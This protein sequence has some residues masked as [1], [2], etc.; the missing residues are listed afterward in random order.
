MSV[1]QRT[2]RRIRHDLSRALAHSADAHDAALA[3]SA[4]FCDSVSPR[5]S[6]GTTSTINASSTGDRRRQRA[7]GTDQA[8]RASSERT[9]IGQCARSRLNF[10]Y[11]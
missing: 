11:A 8:K 4:C 7:G 3:R 5:L 6:Y 2:Y 1:P 10:N 9:G